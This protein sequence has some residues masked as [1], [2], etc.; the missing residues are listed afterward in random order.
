M[1]RAKGRGLYK[2]F[3]FFRRGMGALV[4]LVPGPHGDEQIF[5]TLGLASIC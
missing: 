4:C 3:P 1:A 5:D 2:I